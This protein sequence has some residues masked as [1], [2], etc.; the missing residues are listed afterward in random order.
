MT[1]DGNPCKDLTSPPGQCS[2]GNEVQVLKF[3]ITDCTCDDS[4]NTQ[5]GNFVC[6]EGDISSLLEFL[7]QTLMEIS[8]TKQLPPLEELLRSKMELDFSPMLWFAMSQMRRAAV[9]G[10]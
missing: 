3:K 5:D 1:A 4:L 7:A 9:S 6:G 8:S 10:I 2:V